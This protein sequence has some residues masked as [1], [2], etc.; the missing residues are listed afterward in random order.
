LKKIPAMHPHL[1]K[2]SDSLADSDSD[3]EGGDDGNVSYCSNSSLFAKDRD[4]EDSNDED[5]LEAE[6]MSDDGGKIPCTLEELKLVHSVLVKQDSY[7][8]KMQSRKLTHSGATVDRLMEKAEAHLTKCMAESPMLCNFD[9]KYLDSSK[10]HLSDPATKSFENAVKKLQRKQELTLEDRRHLRMLEKKQGVVQANAD[11]KTS[12]AT[13]EPTVLSPNSSRKKARCEVEEE[14]ENASDTDKEE[15][16]HIDP[17]FIVGTNDIVER[18]FS[19]CRVVLA[20]N[21]GSMAPKTFEALMFIKAN[22]K[23]G[24]WNDIDLASALKRF[25]KKEETISQEEWWK[26]WE[27]HGDKE[28]KDD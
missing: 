16:Q 6:G 13:E 3:M 21:R 8:V 28:D 14:L 2:E 7:C 15:T 4:D 5:N 1:A 25:T 11:G 18:L 27:K 10:C 19:V 24:L 12:N 20:D 23:E 26:D 17:S 9:L 22:L